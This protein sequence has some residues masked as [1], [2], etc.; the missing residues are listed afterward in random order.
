MLTAK[1]GLNTSAKKSYK[2]RYREIANSAWLKRN[3]QG[4]SVEFIKID[5]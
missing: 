2:D 3:Y 4:K 1:F 5:E